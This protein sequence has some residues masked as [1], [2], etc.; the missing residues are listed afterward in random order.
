MFASLLHLGA[1]SSST[2]SASSLNWSG[3]Q[4][5]HLLSERV[6]RTTEIVQL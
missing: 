5:P 2:A 4:Y 1:T 3:A 6:E